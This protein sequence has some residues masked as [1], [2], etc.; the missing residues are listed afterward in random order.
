MITHLFALDN[1]VAQGGEGNGGVALVGWEEFKVLLLRQGLQ[2]SSLSGVHVVMNFV[3]LDVVG[4]KDF[5]N[6]CLQGGA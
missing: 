5:I 6:P 4:G 3:C 1:T 2:G